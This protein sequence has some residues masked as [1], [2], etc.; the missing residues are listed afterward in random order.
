MKP[1][2]N[3]PSPDPQHTDVRRMFDRIAPRYDLLNHLLSAG[4]DYRW[5]HRAAACLS[6]DDP[7]TMADLAT[8][9]ADQV[10]SLCRACLGAPYVIGIDPAGEML[11]RGRAKLQR[12]QLTD[13]ATLLLGDA[14]QLPLGDA[15]VD[16]V[17]ISFGIR[18]VA[19]VE[20]ALGEMRRV[21]VP[22]GLAAVLEFS[23]P[24]NALLRRLHL[25][26]LRH[27]LPFLGG[28]VSGDKD[29]YRYLNRTVEAFPYGQAFVELMTTAGFRHV[30]ATPLTFG[31]ATLYVGKK[32]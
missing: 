3:D 23:L 31:V 16:R 12:L 6:Q 22:G 28:I 19:N 24:A 17:S 27:I 21:L 29:A 11:A 10:V 5:R 9:T 25:F 26:Y 1:V 7:Q 13:R 18:N 14:Q 15:A 4:Q 8:G 32:G 30:T 2:E 20:R